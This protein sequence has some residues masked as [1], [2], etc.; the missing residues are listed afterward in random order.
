MDGDTRSSRPRR[1]KVSNSDLLTPSTL[2]SRRRTSPWCCSA[3]S[4]MHLM[5]SRYE[6]G[7]DSVFSSS[8]AAHVLLLTKK[9]DLEGADEAD[10]GVVGAAAGDEL[11]SQVAHGDQDKRPLEHPRVGDDQVGV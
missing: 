7:R 10:A 1:T 11:W 9:T 5:S 2:A 6:D 3:K 8:G 4:S